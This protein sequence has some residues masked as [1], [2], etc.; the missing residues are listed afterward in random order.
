MA[1]R[2]TIDSARAKQHNDVKQTTGGLQM[3]IT[4]FGHSAYRVETSNSV[5]IIDPFLSGNPVFNGSV[6]EAT[7]GATHVALTHGH[8]DHIGDTAEICKATG[9]TLIAVYELAVHLNAQGAEKIEPTNTGGTIYTEDFNVTFVRADHSSSSGGVP[10]GNPCGLIIKPKPNG[11][12]LYHMG[13]T[14]IFG[15][16]A[17]I[18]EIYK[19]DIGIV[20]IG[21]RFTMR[22][23]TAA[24]A[25]SR[26]FKFSTILPC[27]YGTFPLLIDSADDFVARMGHNAEKVRVLE[28]G[29]SMA[30]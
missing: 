18:N 24:L 28:V 26:F 7:A 8:D 19:P 4:W 1:Y 25:C 12:V 11:P 2:Q 17:L 9:A 23:E 6:E 14:D 30:F 29:G 27:H 22:P 10:L 3:K 21:D 16:M 13:D 15:D 20:P 5:L